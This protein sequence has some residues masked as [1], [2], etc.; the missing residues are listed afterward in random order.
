MGQQRV[1]EDRERERRATGKCC[2]PAACEERSVE[3]T[4]S[5]TEVWRDS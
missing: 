5:A 2:R 3:T 1:D 4:G